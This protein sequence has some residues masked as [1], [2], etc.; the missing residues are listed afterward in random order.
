MNFEEGEG[1]E[2][3]KREGKLERIEND[4]QIDGDRD[5]FKEFMG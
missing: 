5:Y 1:D 4:G 3:K 2:R